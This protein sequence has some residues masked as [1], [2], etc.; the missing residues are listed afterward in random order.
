M[1]ETEPPEQGA[2]VVE[3]V[4][5]MELPLMEDVF[6]SMQARNLLLVDAYLRDLEQGFAAEWAQGERLPLPSAMLVSAMAQMWV[7]AAYEMLRTWRQW[8]R[9]L[10][11]HARRLAAASPPRRAR[12][13]VCSCAEA[14]SAPAGCSKRVSS[15]RSAGETGWRC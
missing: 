12:G 11:E 7:F 14:P 3:A 8:V 1:S 15:V 5:V 9:A 6:L 4:N 13:R 2:G 10:A